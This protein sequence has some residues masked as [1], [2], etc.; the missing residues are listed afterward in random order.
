MDA[1]NL[2]NTDIEKLTE[3]DIKLVLNKIKEYKNLYAAQKSQLELLE[4]QKS[5]LLEEL[6]DIDTQMI[7]VSEEKVLLED[8]SDKARNLAKDVIESVATDSLQQIFN[9][10]RTVSITLGNKGG[11]PTADLFVMHDGDDTDPAKEEGG[12]VADIISTTTFMALSDSMQSVAPFFLDEPNKY[13]SKDYS[14]QTGDFLKATAEFT[15]RQIFMNTHDEHLKTIGDVCYKMTKIGKTT[16]I[17]K[18]DTQK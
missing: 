10:G 2:N 11:Q 12:G 8:S 14:V 7:D 3:A 4:N 17:E 18:V 15:E 9:D 6:N 1:L 5:N 13:V 16:E